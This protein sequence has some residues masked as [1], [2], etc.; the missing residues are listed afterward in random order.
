MKKFY[1]FTYLLLFTL[2]GYQASAIEVGTDVKIGTN[3]NSSQFPQVVS[4]TNGNNFLVVWSGDQD[5]KDRIYYNFQDV[6]SVSGVPVTTGTLLSEIVLGKFLYAE[7]PQAAYDAFSNTAAVVWQESHVSLKDSVVLALINTTTKL[8]TTQIVVASGSWNMS[9]SVSSNH[10]GTYLVVWYDATSLNISGRFYDTSGSPVGSAVVLGSVPSGYLLPYSID[11]DYNSTDAHFLVSWADLSTNLFSRTLK[12]DGTLGVL[13]NYSTISGVINPAIAYNDLTNEFLLV[14]DDFAGNISGILTDNTGVSISSPLTFGSIPGIQAEPDVRLNKDNHAYAISWHDPSLNAGIYFQEYSGTLVPAFTT[15][16]KIDS[17]TATSYAPSIAYGGSEYWISWFGQSPAFKDEIYLQRYDSDYTILKAKCKNVTVSLDAS[18]NYTLTAAEIDNGSSASSG[19]ASMVLSKTA[20][21]CAD[22]STNPNQVTLTV[23]D[24]D[25]NVES[26]TATVTI[27]DDIDPVA[28]AKAYTAELDA[29]GNVTITPANVD[30][31]SSDACGIQSMVLSKTAFTCSDIATNPNVVTLTVTDNHGNTS[32]ADANITVLDKLPP[33]VVGK[34]FSA[35]LDA[36]GTFSLTLGYVLQNAFTS[37]TDNCGL[38][39]IVG[40]TG[41]NYTCNNIGANTLTIYSYDL[42][43]NQTPVTVTLTINDPLNSCNKPPVAVCKSII[44]YADANCSATI[45]ALDIDNGSSDPDNDPLTYSLDNTGPFGVGV[46]SVELTV[47]DGL[48]T[49]KCTATVTVIDNTPPAVVGKDFSADLDVNGTFSLTLGYVLQNAFTSRTD[50]CGLQNVVG[51][52]GANYTCNNIGANTLTI[53]SYDLSGNQTPVTVTLTINDPLNSCNKPPVAACKSIVV[54]ADANCSAIITALDI[55]NGSSDPDND[56]LTYSLDNTGPFGVGVHSVELTVSDGSLTSKCTATVTV[57]DN[58]QPSVTCK[59]ATVYLNSVGA[60]SIVPADV[61][62]TGSDNCGTVNLV[63]VFPNSF[64][65]DNLGSNTVTLTI[66]DGHGNTSTCDATVTV[67]DNTPPSITCPANK[68]SASDTGLCTKTFTAAQIGLP[69]ASDNCSYNISWSRSDAALNLTDPFLFGV[70][71]ITWTATDPTGLTASCNQTIAV[72]KITTNTTVTVTPNSQ[73]YSDLVEF[74][75][76]ISPWNCVG[77]G[78]AG[79]D[80]TF[81]V[82][83]QVMGAPV[84]IG[85]D[86]TATAVYPLVEIP[87]Q[88]SNGQMAPGNHVVLADFNNTDPAF[89]VQDKTTSLLI[90]QEN[91]LVEY[92]GSEF[93]ATQSSTSSLATVTLRAVLKSVTDTPGSGGDIRNACVTFEIGGL[94]IGPLTPQLINPA[95]LTTGVVV[96]NWSTNIGTADYLS[97]DLKV[98]ANCYFTGEDQTVITVYKP[99]GDFITGGGNIKPT[100]SSGVYASTSGLKANFGFHVKFNKKGTSLQGGMNIIFRRQVGG[101]TQL[102]QIKTNSMST[103]G[104]N[105]S[106]PKVKTGVFTSKVNLKNLTTGES[107][108]GNLQLQVKITD[109][110]EPG[111]NDDIAITLWDGN[112]LL[113]SSNWTGLNTAPLLLSG[114]NLVVQSGFGLKST[115]I[116]TGILQLPNSFEVKMYPNPSQGEV[117]LDINGSEIRNS[118]VVVRSIT[119]SEV[120]RKEY[121]AA[122]QIRLDLSKLVSGTYMV[123]LEIDGN[124]IVKKLILDKK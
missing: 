52:T 79:G 112:V 48:L 102:F 59:S 22:I 11:V 40:V 86:G 15:A 81:Y 90:T 41:A 109:R 21:T 123:T 37:R 95:D 43:G 78:N 60:A 74:K 101:E 42:S 47:S 14:Y 31:G 110:G 83:T 73:Q 121:K 8:K 71:T 26:C 75:A 46:H 30:D 5:G 32:T 55:D 70:T 69:T 104:V 80:V 91:A 6:A 44:V 111:T 67:V 115:E 57:V 56:P 120:F 18:G 13:N 23:T 77:G 53:Y 33:A 24:N 100:L 96:Y 4:C 45:T 98:K 94:T 39:N 88:P 58:M 82:G 35:D 63:S 68:T 1:F 116:A 16:V 12:T 38:Q 108:G 93:Q 66:N 114:G 62:L 49:G 119:G 36:N 97:Y 54:N 28:K 106:N 3:L 25:G 118:K 103:L 29:T 99:V 124:L 34:D 27:V 85:S 7:R 19:I 17:Q 107:L 72:D 84:T 64:T 92:V 50:N 105:I 117:I 61:Y 76:T 51:V 2:I 122:E 87:T 89:D 20:F 10:N 9:S 113:Y 65:C